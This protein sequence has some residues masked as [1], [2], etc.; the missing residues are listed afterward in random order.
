MEQTRYRTGRALDATEDAWYRH[1]Q[2]EYVYLRPRDGMVVEPHWTLAPRPLAV[3]LDLPGI[4]R[5][6]RRFPLAGR[7]VPG[8]ALEDLVLALCI[9]GS[10][11]EWTELRWICDIAELVARQP[12]VDWAAALARAETQGCAR[13]LRPGLA[14]AERVLGE[15]LPAA[16]RTATL[17]DATA[18]A[19]AAHVEARLFDVDYD[20]PSVFRVSRFRLRM[21]ERARDRVACL[22]RTL[23]TPQG[24]ERALRGAPAARLPPG[25]NGE[26]RAR[27]AAR[28]PV[29]RAGRPARPQ[30][31]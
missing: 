1:A 22:A 26:R 12:G 14:L 29:G 3:D 4:W 16:A 24:G 20:A 17:A 9:H 11:H 6:A 8:M 23:A 21:R 28:L 19:L 30:P 10:K 13:M 25:G 7:E 27:T 15:P 5:R 2:A 18:L 31:P